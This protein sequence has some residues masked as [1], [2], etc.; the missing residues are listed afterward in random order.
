MENVSFQYI[1]TS[2]VWKTPRRLALPHEESEEELLIE[3]SIAHQESSKDD[4]PTVLHWVYDHA[5]GMP[6]LT[7][8]TSD[9]L[10]EIIPEE[11]IEPVETTDQRYTGL[12]NSYQLLTSDDQPPQV[13]IPRS[14]FEGFEVDS[15]FDPQL[16]EEDQRVHFVRTDAA[17]ATSRTSTQG[18]YVVPDGILEDMLNGL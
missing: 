12:E 1:G 16:F 14:L 4:D 13:G 11:A 15:E 5:M 18:C 9:E 3:G 8:H 7:P 2:T 6:I 10:D 17:Q